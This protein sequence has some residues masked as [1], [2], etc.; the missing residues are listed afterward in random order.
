MGLCLQ[1]LYN[2]FDRKRVAEG[3][4][5][6]HL[7]AHLSAHLEE[8]FTQAKVNTPLAASGRLEIRA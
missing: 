4:Y 3:R 8:S 2:A 5:L 6:A 1:E 7:S